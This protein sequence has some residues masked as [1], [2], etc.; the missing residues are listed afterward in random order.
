VN[1]PDTEPGTPRDAA[2]GERPS[3]RRRR[4]FRRFALAMAGLLLVAV[5]ALAGALAWLLATPSGLQFALSQARPWLPEYVR[6][7]SV[8]GRLIG[9]LRI[10][11]AAIR[12][13]AATVEVERMELDW[14]PAA[15]LAGE[16]HVREVAVE[17]LAVALADT[18]DA[19]AAAGP[20][21]IPELPDELALPLAVRVDRFA[22]TP[23]EL[24]LA[25]GTAHRID[26]VVFG[27]RAGSDA[28]A[29]DSLRIE[30]PAG[31][32]AADL[33]SGA[34]APYPVTGRIDWE[35]DAG[36]ELPPLAGS[37]RFDGTVS[38]LRID[39]ELTAP[40]AVTLN[41]VLRLFDETPA[42]R[43]DLTI[44]SIR[45]AEWLAEAPAIEAGADLRLDGT[46]DTV[47]AS[48]EFDLGSVPGGPYRGRLDL[49][50]DRASL[51]I[52]AFE[53]RP[54]DAD[55]RRAALTGHVD[56]GDGTPRFDLRMDWRGLQWPLTGA[57]SARSP[58]G[59]MTLAGAVDDYR[60]DASARLALPGVGP[61]E[62]A[63]IELRSEGDLNGFERFDTRIDWAGARLAADGRVHWQAPG[64]ARVQAE[65]RDLNPRRFGAAVA[66]RVDA[67]LEATGRWD[68]SGVSGRLTVERLAGEL[69]G[70]A[71]DGGAELRFADG[72]LQVPGL[73]VAAG[74][75]RL[76]ASGRAGERIDIDWS[77]AVPDIRALA[78]TGGGKISGSGRIGG[79]REQ[80][81]ISARFE[82]AE[83][84]WDTVQVETL[85]LDA[86][87]VLSEARDSTATL[88]LNGVEAGGEA[89]ERV[90]ASLSGRPGEHRLEVMASGP[91]GALE[92]TAAG[93]L[94]GVDWRGRLAALEVQPAGRAAWTLA[95]PA[96]VRWVDG[97]GV[98]EELCLRQ[99]P[100]RLCL[101]GEGG[102]DDW[103][104][105]LGAETVP[106]ALIGG[107]GPPDLAYEAQ[108]DLQARLRGGA[109]PVT[110]EARLGITGGRVTGPVDGETHTLMAWEPGSVEATLAAERL[111]GRLEL[112]LA[113]GGRLAATVGVQRDTAATLSGR[114]QA[115]IDDLGLVAALVPEIGRVEGQL[116]ADIGL[117]GTLADPRLSGGAAL[118]EGQVTII[119][120]GIAM[121]ELDLD[122]ETVGQGFRVRLGGRSGEGR[123]QALV[124]L[125]R[126]AGGAWSGEGR[127]SGESFTAVDVPELGLELS[128]DLQWRI[129]GQ[130]VRLDGGIAIPRA[131]IEPRDLS[132][133][134][135]T[136]PDAVIVSA[137][138]KAPEAVAGWR[139]IADVSVELG[140]DVRVD[141]FGLDGRL[142]GA[143]EL[144]ERPGQLT[145]AT[146]EL[147]VEEGTYTIYRQSLQIERGRVLFDGGPVADPGLDVR[148][149]RRPRDV[150]VGVD[151]RGTLR[152]P[153]ATLFSEPPLPESQQLSYLIAG[154]P[155]GESSGSERS[156]MAAAAAALAT[157]EQGR[158]LAG[159]LGIQE[160][161]VDRGEVGSNDG[162][163][164][165]LGRYLSPRLYV[166][167][168]I[169]LAEQAN[170]V[171]MR[172][173]LNRRWSLEARSGAAS[174]ADLLYS[175][176]T[177]GGIDE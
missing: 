15:L 11:G 132:G 65:L 137:D 159:T 109:G 150:I 127:I 9:P 143:I 75:A 135:R 130:T 73:R 148:A 164:L 117:G 31:H 43:A 62:P 48:G 58:Q 133:A 24:T 47:S 170:S 94:E 69:D 7:E 118:E 115:R 66:G 3:I 22:V 14:N 4:R 106:L 88:S 158:E 30:A 157:S 79:S 176:E 119:P 2:A 161:T 20:P 36:G 54:V 166:G 70:R 139:I 102:A 72:V 42:W 84:Q 100:A 34:A 46:L 28:L 50:A 25:D 153:R 172:Y 52:G 111:D 81:S 12:L 89:L 112:P 163:S 67:G 85:V 13:D 10:D 165:V 16:V 83:L 5:L 151:V 35:W 116:N 63:T 18:G 146:G 27:V 160:V 167:Y 23:I 154:V 101:S 175:I 60:L 17:G 61:D 33:E 136:S 98:V 26:Q 103:S 51:R 110:G 6:I 19:P 131:R 134:V 174:S 87:A 140:D 80:P 156:A 57:P 56:Y 129:E 149:V 64:E 8:E 128:P 40:T 96:P 91:R 82:G 38:E 114:V 68:A 122:L 162:A 138:D 71:L 45:P 49:D 41:A 95:E 37:G 32:V 171:R 142:G 141:A 145:T 86:D 59:R 29:L 97:R 90:R 152:E 123:V 125:R 92:F 55:D 39:H 78:G 105:R 173:E 120:L 76:E 169:G 44:A 21:T 126:G 144:R 77:V 108:L 1:E 113:D 53:I 107:F 155:L 74:D 99:R 124:D 121:T 104:A 177:E 168:G 93:A 147:R